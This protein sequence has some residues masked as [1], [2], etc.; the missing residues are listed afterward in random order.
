M[1]CSTETGG[2]VQ[3]NI[4]ITSQFRACLI[5]FGL[6]AIL[7]EATS[8]DGPTSN[9][10]GGTVR[11]MAPEIFDPERYGYVKRARRKLPSKSTDIYGLGMTILEACANSPLL[12]PL[13]RNPDL[14]R[15][16]RAGD[17]SSIS[18]QMLR[19]YRRF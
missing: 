13:S 8:I 17:P 11:W 18:I 14:L 9:E 3:A 5:D 15:L 16:S 12:L 2:G 19:S 4:L 1:L 6:S 7:V 10:L